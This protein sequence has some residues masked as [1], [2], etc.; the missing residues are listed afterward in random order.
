MG[1]KNQV[2]VHLITDD[3][4]RSQPSVPVSQ[5]VGGSLSQAFRPPSPGRLSS[6]LPEVNPKPSAPHTR[7]VFVS[8]CIQGVVTA[9]PKTVAFWAGTLI[10]S[11]QRSQPCATGGSEGGLAFR[12]P[13]KG[14]PLSSMAIG[15]LGP[16]PP[17]APTPSSPGIF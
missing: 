3:P 5:W 15:A 16:G 13:I 7:S 9:A 4:H 11:R 12:G 10:Q 2:R 6:P 17:A 14:L 1:E 8:F